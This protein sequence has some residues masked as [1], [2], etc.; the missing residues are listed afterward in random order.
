VW[1][2]LNGYAKVTTVDAIV[3]HGASLHCVKVG[4]LCSVIAGM[5]LMLIQGVSRL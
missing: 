4:V 2:R 1:I 5:L 3:V